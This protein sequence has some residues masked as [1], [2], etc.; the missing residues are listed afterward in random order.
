MHNFCSV[1]DY[2][3][4]VQTLGEVKLNR[5]KSTLAA[6]ALLALAAIMGFVSAERPNASAELKQLSEVRADLDRLT[7][8]NRMMKERLEVFRQDF[9]EVQEGFAT[10]SEMANKI[11]GK[12]KNVAD[13]QAG[14]SDLSFSMLTLESNLQW[15]ES[16]VRTL[17]PERAV[18]VVAQAE[19]NITGEKHD[20]QVAMK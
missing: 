18:K 14:A 9:N 17:R 6:G 8:E 16:H 12:S 19:Q 20:S 4:R 1:P 11:P 3:G 7:L 5:T 13:V 2:W 15:M 10:L